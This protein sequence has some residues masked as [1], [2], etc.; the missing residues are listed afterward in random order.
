MKQLTWFLTLVLITLGGLVFASDHRA[1]IDN[2]L[3]KIEIMKEHL[4]KQL[5]LKKK[6]IEQTRTL[7]ALELALESCEDDRG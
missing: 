2:G 4:K 5:D 6:L 3:E 1:E 7:E